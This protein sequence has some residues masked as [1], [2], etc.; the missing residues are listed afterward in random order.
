[1]TFHLK[2]LIGIRSVKSEFYQ[3]TTLNQW[4]LA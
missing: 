4:F 2:W 1:M 3:K